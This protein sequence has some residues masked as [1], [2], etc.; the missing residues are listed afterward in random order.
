LSRIFFD[1]NL[2]IYLL[3]GADAA[4]IR[5]RQIVERMAGRRDELLTS[6]FTLAEVLVRP[7][8]MGNRSL[9]E[10]YEKLLCE[11]RVTLVDFDRAAARIY[12]GLRQ[13]KSL[14]APD[15]IQLACAAKARTD[16]FITND[17]HLAKN[18]VPGIQFIA[19]LDNA[20]L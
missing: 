3:E 19:S 15:G 13:D 20:W 12:A 5:V 14:K 6:S 11:P 17:N 18:I 8:R 1:T 16:L 7:V 9:A 4:A 2:F 10:E